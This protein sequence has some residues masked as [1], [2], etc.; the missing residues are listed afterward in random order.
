MANWIMTEM[1]EW[2][3]QL[4]KTAE[5][6]AK[7][8]S[9]VYIHPR[10]VT[11]SDAN[12]KNEWLGYEEAADERDSF[13]AVYRE[14]KGKRSVWLL[15]C[16]APNGKYAGVRPTPEQRK[17]GL[18]QWDLVESH[19]WAVALVDCEGKDKRGCGKNLYIFDSDMV[20][21]KPYRVK[22]LRT[23]RQRKLVEAARDCMKISGV[24]VSNAGAQ[25][26]GRDICLQVATE[27]VEQVVAAGLPEHCGGSGEL[28]ALFD[29]YLRLEL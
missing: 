20:M 27:W 25:N 5:E 28:E 19:A 3:A 26:A 6:E 22:D 16:D 11:Y 12:M 18:R 29:G 13:S 17:Q 15:M 14:S 4:Q 2:L 9:Y 23:Q 8:G 7:G 10:V 1:L 21:G 24:F